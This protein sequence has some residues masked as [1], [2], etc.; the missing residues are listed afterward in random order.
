[1]SA[2]ATA[3]AWRQ[4][5]ST[6]TKFILIALA[7][8]ADDQHQAPLLFERI[9]SLTGLSETTIRKSVSELAKADLIRRAGDVIRIDKTLQNKLV[10]NYRLVVTV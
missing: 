2:I 5:L 10:Q 4:Q 3:W 1:M 9:T 6:T 7:E 8:L